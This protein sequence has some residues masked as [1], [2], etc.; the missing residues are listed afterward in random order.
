MN[1]YLARYGFYYPVTWL[2]GEG[3][4]GLLKQTREF[5]WKSPADIAD[6]QLEKAI[7]IASRAKLH[8]AFYRQHYRNVDLGRIKSLADFSRLPGVSKNDLVE[9]GPNFITDYKSRCETKTTGGSTGHPVRVVKNAEA[10]GMER[11]VTW[12]GYEW[13]GIT[14]GDP[15]GRFWGVPHTR[16]GRMKAALTDFIANRKRLSAFDLD[17]ESLLGYYRQLRRFKPAYLY[18]YVSVMEALARFIRDQKLPAL[19]G[20]TSIVTTAEILYPQSRQLIESVFGVKVYNEY[21]CGEVGSVAHECE[22]G[23]LH[24]MADNLLLEIDGDGDGEILLTDF[25]NY[26][27]PLV[28]YRVGDFGRLSPEPCACGRGL[29]VLADVYGRAYDLLRLDNGRAIHP[30]ALIY[31]LEDFKSES[32][33][34]LQFQAIQRSHKKVDILVVPNDGWNDG[35]A[36]RL[37]ERMRTKLSA[38]IDYSIHVVA[39]IAREKSGKMRLV[40]SE[41]AAGD[42]ALDSPAVLG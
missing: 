28:R 31:V 5:Q 37:K 8:S 19:S 7:T 38:G 32:N 10:L 36:A 11:A 41:V 30:E 21:G 13:A 42:T 33:A 39:E 29:P 40:K 1:K 3:V 12:R 14:V 6:Y 18:G 9:Q 4:A 20:L 16:K 34:V 15:Q 2:K 25:F 35:I 22:Q 17:D 24:I 23:R 26:K 27:T